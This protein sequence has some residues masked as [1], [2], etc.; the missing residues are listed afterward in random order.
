M[1]KN[2]ISV[3]G[4]KVTIYVFSISNTNVIEI[5]DIKHKDHP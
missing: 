4:N 2:M 3:S 5:R 1:K